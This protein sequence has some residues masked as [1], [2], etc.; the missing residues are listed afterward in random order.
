MAELVKG[1]VVTDFNRLNL[2]K[3]YLFDDDSRRRTLVQCLQVFRREKSLCD[4]FLHLN[5]ETKIS[6][7]RVVLTASSPYFNALFLANETG[8]FIKSVHL[9][10]DLSP[11]TAE[12]IIDYMYSGKIYLT[13][14]N[15]LEILGA[16]QFF[17]LQLLVHECCY[18]LVKFLTLENCKQVQDF[19]LSY[20]HVELYERSSRFFCENFTKLINT[21]EFLELPRD[22]LK[23]LF[24]SDEIH[25]TDEVQ[26]PAVTNL[27]CFILKFACNLWF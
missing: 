15:C 4:V 12:A 24:S 11:V 7:H 19:A 14:E 2:H 22:K 18:A 17:Q 25:V 10:E 3:V 27:F 8:R 5:N 1:D 9:P 13:K 23:V 26:V 20:G 16:A 6:A 21:R